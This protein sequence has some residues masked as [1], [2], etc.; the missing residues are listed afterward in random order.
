MKEIAIHC[1][2][3]IK[4]L[5]GWNE[6]NTDDEALKLLEDIRSSSVVSGGWNFEYQVYDS[7]VREV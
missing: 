1:S 5:D 6:D 7:E 3:Y 4:S 2:I